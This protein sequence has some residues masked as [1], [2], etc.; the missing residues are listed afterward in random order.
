MSAT[1]TVSD[2][3]GDTRAQTGPPGGMVR[4]GVAVIVS[5]TI[6]AILAAFLLPVGINELANVSTTSWTDASAS[7]FELLELVFVLVIFL[8]AIGWAVRSFR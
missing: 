1:A 3:V 7:L 4:Q 8:V 5:V 2:F 6:A